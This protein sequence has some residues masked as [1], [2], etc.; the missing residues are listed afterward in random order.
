M[1]SSSTTETVSELE[2]QAR[3]LATYAAS[4]NW[5]PGDNTREWLLGLRDLIEHVQALTRPNPGEM[6]SDLNLD[7]LLRAEDDG[8]CPSCGFAYYGPPAIC[9]CGTCPRQCSHFECENAATRE[10]CYAAEPWMPYCDEHTPQ[11]GT[12]GERRIPR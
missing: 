7:E 8:D 6:G 9:T 1:T 12:A 10:F 2:R 3:Y 5:E 11:Y 4:V